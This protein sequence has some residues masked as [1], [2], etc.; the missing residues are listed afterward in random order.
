[1]LYLCPEP[2]GGFITTSEINTEGNTKFWGD[3]QGL[4]DLGPAPSGTTSQAVSHTPAHTP[5][6]SRPGPA[7]TQPP[8]RA[9]PGTCLLPQITSSSH[10]HF[11]RSQ[12][13]G[14]G[15]W[16]TPSQPSLFSLFFILFFSWNLPPLNIDFSVCLLEWEVF[17][18]RAFF[19]SLP[20]EGPKTALSICVCASHSVV[21]DPLPIPWL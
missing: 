7:D 9:L 17:K 2:S 20:F 14:C 6:D 13:K 3:Q 11:F 15:F 4:S 12:H 8:A 5:A 1:M 16:K 21:S 19:C 18:A 10:P